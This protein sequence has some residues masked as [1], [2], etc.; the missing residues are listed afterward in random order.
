MRQR[1]VR[2]A[3]EK[4]GCRRRQRGL[5]EQEMWLEVAALDPGVEQFRVTR[6]VLQGQPLKGEEG[7]GGARGSGSTVSS[8]LGPGAT[9]G[10]RGGQKTKP[11]VLSTWGL[12][13]GQGPQ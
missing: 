3:W 1:E 10:R 2:S 12:T 13:R 4:C 8:D 6:P 9:W 7:T 11:R 5:G